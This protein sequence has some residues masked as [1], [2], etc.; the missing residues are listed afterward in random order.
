MSRDGAQMP[1]PAPFVKETSEGET[2]IGPSGKI[3]VKVDPA[4]GASQ[5]AMG[6]QQ[7]LPNTGIPLHVHE[8][9]DEIL[10]VHA[11]TA[12]GQIA[13]RRIPV[14]P[15]SMM[16]IPRGVWHG[17]TNP[18]GEVT[19]VWFVSPPGLE[20][21]FRATRVKPGEPVRKLTPEELNEIALKHG[22]RF[23]PK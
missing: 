8:T 19:L 3:I 15:G 10:F 11:G 2:L 23:E 17:V 7:L 14:Q 18:D 12:L 21:F 9:E 22:M 20:A 4:T 6:T 16:F 5:F 1:V 13:D